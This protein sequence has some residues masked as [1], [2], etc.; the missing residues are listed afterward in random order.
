MYEVLYPV[1]HG[2]SQDDGL[3]ILPFSH[4]LHWA[5]IAGPNS[6]LREGG[7]KTDI[8]WQAGATLLQA[9]Q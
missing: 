7:S 2:F 6:I 8:L 5:W 3:L 1:S 4:R 9:G